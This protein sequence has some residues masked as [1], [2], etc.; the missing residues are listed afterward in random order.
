MFMLIPS[1]PDSSRIRLV[2]RVRKELF[3]FF[4]G[5]FLL[6]QCHPPSPESYGWPV[7][8]VEELPPYSPKQLKT[9]VIVIGNSVR[10]LCI[11]KLP[12]PNHRNSWQADPATPFSSA[13]HAANLLGDNAYLVEQLGFGHSSLAQVSSCTYAVLADYLLN[14]TVCIILPGQ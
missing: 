12:H 3:F 14:S 8:S 9:P 4:F 13:Q 2:T 11:G 10:I 1:L 7:R 6:K 5:T